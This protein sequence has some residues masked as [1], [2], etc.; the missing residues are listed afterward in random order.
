MSK[1]PET[2]YSLLMRLKASEDECSR[3]ADWQAFVSSYEPFIYRYARRKGLQDTD[4]NDLVQKVMVSVAKSISNW[5]P[6]NE[7]NGKPRFRNWLFTIARNHLLNA[8]KVRSTNRGVGGTTQLQLLAQSI[9]PRAE[10]HQMDED[11]RREAFLW[12]ATRVR[13]QVKSLTWLAFWKTAVEGLDCQQV[14]LELETTVGNVYAS[15]SRVLSRLKAEVGTFLAKEQVFRTDGY[16][17][18]FRTEAES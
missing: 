4:A 5:Q 3:D 12:A 1:L 11:Y 13:K 16:E 7:S 9:D 17:E 2:Q 18:L 15:R 10:E 6:A 14:S 8:L